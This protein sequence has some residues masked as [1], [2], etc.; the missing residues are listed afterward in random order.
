[1][2]GGLYKRHVE[3][4]NYKIGGKPR[5]PAKPL[6]LSGLCT[7]P[8]FDGDEAEIKLSTSACLEE[9]GRRSGCFLDNVSDVSVL[10]IYILILCEA[11]QTNLFDYQAFV[12]MVMVMAMVMVMLLKVMVMV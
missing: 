11:S 10:K 5:F 7:P 9:N 8:L 3:I 1:M 6:Q 4:S 12:L 2:G